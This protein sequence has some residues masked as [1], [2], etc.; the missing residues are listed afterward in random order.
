ML[1]RRLLVPLTIAPLVLAGALTGTASASSSPTV[2][3]ATTTDVATSA[4][5]A[6]VTTQSVSI[7]R[8]NR[9]SKASVATQRTPRSATCTRANAGLRVVNTS[10]SAQTIR[11][12][13]K[14]ARIPAGKVLPICGKGTSAFTITFTVAK[15]GDKLP[16]RFR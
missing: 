10:G 12:Q 3:M 1:H 13:G 5:L 9:W 8:S 15:S 2:T 6:A 7:T 4:D 16:V 11:A 14:S